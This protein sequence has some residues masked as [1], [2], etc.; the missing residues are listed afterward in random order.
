VVIGFPAIP[1]S[2]LLTFSTTHQVTARMFS[3][4]TETMG[5]GEPL[6]DVVLLVVGEDSLDE[7][8][9]DQW[10]VSAS[11]LSLGERSDP[12]CSSLPWAASAAYW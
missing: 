8:H 3:P 4:S 10:H 12:W 11:L 1:Q 2:P 6:D 5:V 9:V 7:L